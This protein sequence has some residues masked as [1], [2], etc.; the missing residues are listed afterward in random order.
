M[1]E[2]YFT[3]EDKDEAANGNWSA[4]K[5]PEDCY[6][7]DKW[8]L[9]HTDFPN[10]GRTGGY[11]PFEGNYWLHVVERKFQEFM[12]WLEKQ[13]VQEET[14]LDRLESYVNHPSNRPVF[15]GHQIYLNGLIEQVREEQ[16]CIS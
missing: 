13:E 9:E 11:P 6:N 4:S 16:E 14:A 1:T 12:D 3:T 7:A 8:V 5:I 2:W 15:E 10:A